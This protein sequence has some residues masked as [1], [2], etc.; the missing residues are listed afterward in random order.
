MEFGEPAP[1]GGFEIAFTEAHATARSWNRDE[2]LVMFEL[3]PGA[4]TG[5]SSSRCS[6]SAKAM[7][8]PL[9]DELGP[10]PVAT[11]TFWLY[12]SVFIESSFTGLF[13]NPAE[14]GYS[15]GAGI[16]LTVLVNAR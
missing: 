15:A 12:D 14:N 16:S 2:A 11:S 8:R 4:I 5:S 3:S 13:G 10:G 9:W 6:S 1:R 7:R